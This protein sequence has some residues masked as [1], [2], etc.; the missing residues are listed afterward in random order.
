LATNNIPSDFTAL[1]FF[2][3]PSI[4]PPTTSLQIPLL[5]S[6][7]I[8]EWQRNQFLQYRVSDERQMVIGIWFVFLEELRP[9]SMWSMDFWVLVLMTKLGIQAGNSNRKGCMWDQ[10]NSTLFH[11]LS[12]SACVGSK[13]S[14]INQGRIIIVHHEKSSTRWLGKHIH[15]KLHCACSL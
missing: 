14:W 15:V 2:D 11:S 1:Q 7:W 10:M 8:S 12:H 6:F 9:K 3:S 4:W 5:F 13:D